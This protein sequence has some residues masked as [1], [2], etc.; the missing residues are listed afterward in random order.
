MIEFSVKNVD[1]FLAI[2]IIFI[3]IR[4]TSSDELLWLVS[5]SDKCVW[6]RHSNYTFYLFRNCTE[7]CG[8]LTIQIVES[9]TITLE[10]AA[11]FIGATGVGFVT[12]GI[13]RGVI[14][15][16]PPGMGLKRCII[17][18]STGHW[19]VGLE[20]LDC[21][22]LFIQLRTTMDVVITVPWWIIDGTG[23]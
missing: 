22:A 16:D 5:S 20:T 7:A 9:S 11:I 4:F 3:L 18:D 1:A 2:W 8:V 21:G 14:R 15:V 17:W 23:V 6:K 19:N 12:A 13:E 10:D